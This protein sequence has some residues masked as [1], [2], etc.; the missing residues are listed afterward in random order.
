M[1]RDWILYIAAF[2]VAFGVTLLTTP[3]S[4]K[5]SFKIGRKAIDY[6]KKRG[7]HTEPKPRLGGVAIFLGF[8][9]SVIMLMLFVPEMRTLQFAGFFV[10]GVIIFS[11][12][13]WDDIVRVSPK[14]KF[15]GQLL[16]ASVVVATGS[17]IN[18]VFWPFVTYLEGFSIPFTIL[19][20][21][22]VINAI[23]LIDG[24]DGLAAGVS[25]ISAFCL[26]VL[27]VMT[28]TPL[29]VVLAAA[30]A[31]SCFGFLPRNFNPS[32]VIM[33]D[34]GALFLGYVLG[35][36][37]IIG[38]YKSYAL[39]SVLITLFALALPIFDTLFA[40]IRRLLS[41]RSFAE[42]DRGHLHHRLIDAGYSQKQA[43]FILYGISVVAS[44][45]AVLIALKDI[46]AILVMVV[47]I[48]VFLVMMYVYR[49][50][51]Q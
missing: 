36:S 35:V 26:M 27:C 30:L 17:R 7:V 3:F 14:I 2:A 51:T 6:P 40:I 24:L 44:I 15:L 8:M 28:G 38:V 33:G 29:A 12:G 4:K 21:I 18:I 16:A 46:R 41:G 43:V 23:N 47:V 9:V 1:N 32:E 34:C 25:S 31:G 20:I 42:A 22:A 13:M 37:S 50:R 49:N 11:L 5:L 19:W 39:L 10:G 48:L 45:I